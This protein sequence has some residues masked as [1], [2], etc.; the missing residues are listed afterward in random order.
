M[1]IL[2]LIRG[3]N[4]IHKKKTPLN[5]V[6]SMTLSYNRLMYGDCVDPLKLGLSININ[7]DFQLEY[8]GC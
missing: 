6:C 8:E 5:I 7:T 3:T 1:D 2:I 4:L